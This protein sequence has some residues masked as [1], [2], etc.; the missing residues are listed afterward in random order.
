MEAIDSK[1]ED[2]NLNII[3]EN[4]VF[5]INYLKQLFDKEGN[6]I[7]NKVCELIISE[8]SLKS[9]ISAEECKH[10]EIY[11]FYL[12]F[13]Q[14]NDVFNALSSTEQLDYIYDIVYSKMK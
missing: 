7:L 8:I 3:N 5:Y 13:I 14:K 10:N 1:T 9:W 6:T 12:L 2:F 11:V 4:N